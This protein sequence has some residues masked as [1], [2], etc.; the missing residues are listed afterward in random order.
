MENNQENCGK[1]NEDEFYSSVNNDIRNSF[2]LSVTIIV[3]MYILSI[4]LGD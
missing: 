3:I 1:R 2:V 4:I